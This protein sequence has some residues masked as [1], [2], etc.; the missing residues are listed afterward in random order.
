[1]GAWSIRRVL[2]KAEDILVEREERRKG[3]A[4]NGS[5]T[6]SPRAKYKR[7]VNVRFFIHCTNR[8]HVQWK[9]TARVEWYKKEEGEGGGSER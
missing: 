3:R 5:T 4:R 7:L 8:A 6:S 1:M 2:S 9:I